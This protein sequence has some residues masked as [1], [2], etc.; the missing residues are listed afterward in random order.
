MEIHPQCS[1]RGCYQTYL[2]R[3]TDI[4]MDAKHTLLGGG[5]NGKEKQTLSDTIEY[6]ATNYLK[7]IHTFIQTNM[8]D[9]SK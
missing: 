4:I 3:H 9:L 6:L 1:D 5:N 7:G 2:D 8:C